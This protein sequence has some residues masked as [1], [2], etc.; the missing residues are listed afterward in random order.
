MRQHEPE[1]DELR[2]KVCVVTFEA[3]SLATAYA[4][5]TG[6]TWPLLVDADRA[7]YRA[8]GMERG[9]AWEIFGPASLWKYATLLA[10]GRRLR[11]PGSDIH[12][13]GGDVL[14]D[15]EGTVRLHRVAAGPADR[16][17]L[18]ELLAPIRNQQPGDS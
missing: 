16:P 18:G 9:S 1:L 17:S 2:V 13:L 8:Y 12:Q 11:Q 7:L 14:I 6:L 4:R 10:R 5:E 15:P 3:G